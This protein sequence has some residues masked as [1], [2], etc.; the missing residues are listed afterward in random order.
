MLVLF[1]AAPLRAPKWYKTKAG[2]SFGFG[3]KLVSFRTADTHTPSGLSE[4]CLIHYMKVSNLLTCVCI[5]VYSSL[6]SQVYVHNVVTEES[7]LSRSSEFEAAIQNGERSSLKLLCEKK[8]QESEYVLFHEIMEI[9]LFV[10]LVF[11]PPNLWDSNSFH[12]LL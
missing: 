9:F 1:T 3:G 7:L 10:C 4:V 6:Q 12:W 2:V 11:F 8:S 5:F